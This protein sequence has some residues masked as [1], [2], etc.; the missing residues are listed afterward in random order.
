MSKEHKFGFIVEGWH[1]EAIIRHVFPGIYPIVVLRGNGFSK[2]IQTAINTASH[3][4]EKL[5]IATD[6]DTAGDMVAKKIQEV[7]DLPRINFDRE[8]CLAYDE[9]GK[10]RKVGV[11]H[12]NPYYIEK[13]I[14]K[15]MMEEEAM[16]KTKKM[17][18]INPEVLM[19]VNPRTGG[20][21]KEGDLRLWFV[22]NKGFH[23][24]NYVK[25]IAEA[26]VTIMT[27]RGRLK[28]QTGKKLKFG[29]QVF[30]N[31]E[32]HKWI[33]TKHGNIEEFLDI[34]EPIVEEEFG[35]ER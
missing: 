15:A 4:C 32:W 6:P 3:L 13:T 7:F 35:G 23:V 21:F 5:Y 31:G 26:V 17:L 30:H 25:D 22:Y 2:S 34:A 33:D 18:A 16:D 9:R 10:L 24:Y 27:E 14:K 29:L 1:D 11:E 20:V 28:H 12:A 8:K 19:S